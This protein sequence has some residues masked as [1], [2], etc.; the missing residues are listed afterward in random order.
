MKRI[1]K[2][3]VQW[4]D[5]VSSAFGR[6]L[7]HIFSDSGVL[8][9]FFLAGLLY[10]I[11]YGLIYSNDSVENMPVAAVDLSGSSESR[12][13]VRELDATRE[14]EIRYT[15]ADM[16]EAERLMQQRKV[17]GIVM[18]PQEFG[19][20]I[21]RMQPATV[22]TYG[23]MSSFLY[24]KNLT[25]GV[26]MVM[27]EEMHGIQAGRF[28]AAGYDVRQVSQMVRPLKYEE[29]SPYNRN[30]SYGLFFLSAV[31]MIVVQQT[32][33]YGMSMLTGTM[34]EE[35][36]R[37]AVMPNRLYRNRACRTDHTWPFSP[38]RTP[39]ISRTVIGR[40]A[41]YWLIYMGIGSYIAGIV[42]ALVGMPQ[43]C[44][45]G[46]I[47]ILLLFYVTACVVFSLTFSSFIRH[48]ETVFVIF[49]LMSPICLFLTGF[50][51]PSS[52]FPWF[53][54][55]FSCIFPSTFAA[56]AFINMNTAGA[57]LAMCSGEIVALTVQIIV[58]YLLSCLVAGI[59]SR[60]VTPVI[61]GNHD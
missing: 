41:A 22:S 19:D 5:D 53:W 61:A 12:G 57:S 18:I 24:Y 28:S 20:N 30:F 45:F 8:V 51:W 29:N 33:F 39:G 10:P 17:H 27:L 6:E 2:Y 55:M 43:N 47:F 60:K 54:K 40:G 42:P 15:C 48:R 14:I 11:L 50:S 4:R 59:R 3:I 23:D 44:P 16:A 37:L 35:D 34:K 49:L 32:M 31:L 9:I 7:K 36:R 25:M 1:I 56:R 21:A 58:Y 13:F 26:N 52:S 46:E 38:Y